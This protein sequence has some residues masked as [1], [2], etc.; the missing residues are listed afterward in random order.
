MLT[1]PVPYQLREQCIFQGALIGCQTLGQRTSILPRP[2]GSEPSDLGGNIK[3][4]VVVTIVIDPAGMVWSHGE[5]L[6]Y[7]G[8]RRNEDKL[9]TW[10]ATA[11]TRHE[12][13]P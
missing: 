11:G 9:P 3:R 2:E 4:L 13:V 6:P 1:K 5:V 10:T 12:S 7:A 8:H